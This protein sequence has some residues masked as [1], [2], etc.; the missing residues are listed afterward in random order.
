MND[1]RLNQDAANADLATASNV[2]EQLASMQA[3]DAVELLNELDVEDAVGILA[4]MPRDHAVLIL[5]QPEL[6]SSAEIITA[7][8]PVIAR[9]LLDAMSADRVTDIFQ[10]FDDETRIRLAASLGQE[11]KAALRKLLHYPPHTAGSLMTTEFVSVPA[12]WSVAATL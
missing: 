7:L 10:Q 4:E 9:E 1:L 6:H 5:D 8:P 11:T 12:N 2:A 3:A